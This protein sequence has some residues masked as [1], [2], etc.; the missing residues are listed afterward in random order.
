[1]ARSA[2]LKLARAASRGF[3]I[4][5][6]TPRISAPAFL[7]PASAQLQS[8]TFHALRFISQSS[9]PRGI[10]PDNQPSKQA[11]TPPVTR[12]PAPLTTPE[13][14]T[15]AD[16]YLDRLLTALEELQ[17][18]REDVD[19]EYQVR[20]EKENDSQ[21]SHPPQLSNTPFSRAES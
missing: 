16:A 5:R 20:F 19:V 11:V 3:Q 7:R 12:T 8:P 15:L 21:T 13:Y 2:T 10:T 4:A 9:T 18:Q 1:M 6:T 14:H 17:D